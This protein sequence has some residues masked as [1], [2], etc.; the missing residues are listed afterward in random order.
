MTSLSINVSPDVIIGEAFNAVM[1][2][3]PL[4]RIILE[5]TEHETVTN[6]G[7]LVRALAP[8]RSRGLKIAVDDAGA[9]HS[10]LRHIL[11]LKP[12]LIKL[13]MS[14][15]QK[16]DRDPSR[17]ALAAALIAFSREIGSELV[18]EG[19]ETEG[20]L[21]ALRKLGVDIAQGYLLSQPLPASQLNAFLS[22]C[23]QS[24][25]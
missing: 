24:P 15:I 20:E 23:P 6:Y 1:Q 8:F 11:K 21:G 18:A 13:D 4:D 9:G 5:I 17:H 2:S 10:S 25:L 22:G 14:L 3:A 16:I 12:D 7:A 19:V